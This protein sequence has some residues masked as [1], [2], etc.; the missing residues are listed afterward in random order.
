VYWIKDIATDKS[1]GGSL[2]IVTDGRQEEDNNDDQISV[3]FTTFE[4]LEFIYKNENKKW[5][6][7]FEGS[8]FAFAKSKSFYKQAGLYHYVGESLPARMLSQLIDDPDSLG[9]DLVVSNSMPIWLA[10]GGEIPIFPAYLVQ[11]N[12]K[13]PYAT[14]SIGDDATM[15]LTSFPVFNQLSTQWQLVKDRVKITLY[16]TN[17]NE[18]LDFIRLIMS[19]S[20]DG[21]F[22][23]MTTPVVKDQREKKTEFDILAK[24]KVIEITIDYYQERAREIALKLLLNATFDILI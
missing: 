19:K 9:S 17:N 20:L 21:D 22:G 18:A 7:E 16:G 15:A 23:V 6:G 12:Q 1:V 10:M 13:L 3:V 2:H 24:K 4:N 8:K 14:I 5:I 11:K